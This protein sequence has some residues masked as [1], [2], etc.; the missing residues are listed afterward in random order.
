MTNKERAKI[1]RKRK[2]QYYNDLEQKNKYL[3]DRVSKLT[4]ELE[5]FK[6]QANNKESV[7][8]VLNSRENLNSISQLSNEC[9]NMIRSIPD[10]S[11]IFQICNRFSEA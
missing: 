7:K 6:T 8:P 5:L 9:S 4:K 1:A 10:E 3:E 2:K 11:H